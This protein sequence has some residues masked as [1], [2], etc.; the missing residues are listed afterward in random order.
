MA[1]NKKTASN[2]SSASKKKSIPATSKKPVKKAS[3]QIDK[4][5]AEIISQ[6]LNKMNLKFE[7][8]IEECETALQKITKNELELSQI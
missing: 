5:K 4:T 6:R 2:P 1:K 7:N 8:L 3:T